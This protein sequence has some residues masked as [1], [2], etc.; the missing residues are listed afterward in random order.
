MQKLGWTLVFTAASLEHLAERNLEADDVA[1][2]VFSRYGLA[3][4]RRAG[5]GTA[6]RWFIVAP[7]DGGEFLTCARRIRGISTR[8]AR[9]LCRPRARPGSV[10]NSMRPCGYAL[11][12][13]SQ[14]RTKY[15][16]TAPGGAAKEDEDER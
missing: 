4:V 3:R 1:D 2:A 8:K 5:R 6:T 15:G 16:V 12:H 14:R 13:A 9:S 7:L 11:V 10:W